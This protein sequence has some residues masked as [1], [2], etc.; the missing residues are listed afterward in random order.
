MK[1]R[2][3]KVYG[4]KVY[5][6]KVCGSKVCGS[7]VRLAALVAFAGLSTGVFAAPPSDELVKERADKFAAE[8]RVM[9]ADSR[10]A[11]E[12]LRLMK[13]AEAM[14]GF[15]LD[16]MTASQI[17]TFDR[18][19]VFSFVGPEV[20]EQV[21]ARLASLSAEPTVEGAEAA[22]LAIK[23]TP[24]YV[25]GRDNAEATLKN[26]REAFERL[27]DHPAIGQALSEGKAADFY[28]SFSRG[29]PEVFDGLNIAKRIAKLVPAT[30][31]P[32]AAL[33]ATSLGR[34]LH[35]MNDSAEDK[36][37]AWDA[38]KAMVTTG[39][40]GAPAE[41]NP[42]L[43]Q[44][45]DKAV[46]FFSVVGS[47]MPKMEITWSSDPSISSIDSLKGKVVVIDFWATWCGPCRSAFPNVAKLTH[48]YK[49]YPVTILGVTS[50]QGSHTD[51][52]A[53]DKLA[54]K[55]TGLQ[56]DPN[57]EMGLMPSF[58]KNWEMTWPVVFTDKNCFNPDYGV[59]G[60]P[61]VAI[62]DAEGIVRYNGMSPH[63]DITHKTQI[64]NDLLKKA[65]LPT[66]PPYVEPAAEPA[67]TSDSRPATI[68]A[69]EIKELPAKTGS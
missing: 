69:S 12:Q 68:P 59:S 52:R 46:A 6:S 15:S 20:K 64:I 19:R 13:V 43:L 36:A 65:G 33:R 54:Q 40:D 45:Y 32:D 50:L 61:H 25:A 3:S 1:T 27:L 44:E 28:I 62:V 38:L 58:M 48:Y 56:D 2:G 18:A 30:G 9:K 51:P 37:A 31:T 47:P 55:I 5:G 16:E 35:D 29:G 7:L 14:D 49:D 10:E 67:K 22:V 66:P 39:R 57:R 21:A 23:Y 60:I 17:T 24:M 63:G 34:G 42:R 8:T 41:T 53:E 4:S 26:Q 11:M